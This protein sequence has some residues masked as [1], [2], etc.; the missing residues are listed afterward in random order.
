MV[1]EG[2][3]KS[4]RDAEEDAAQKALD[5]YKNLKSAYS[6]KIGVEKKLK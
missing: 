5:F 1:S 4:K 6:V 2:E 3:G